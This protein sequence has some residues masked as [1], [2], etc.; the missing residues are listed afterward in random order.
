MRNSKQNNCDEII[1]LLVKNYRSQ[2]TSE[3]NKKVGE[4]A[5]DFINQN[6][7]NST[8]RIS[9]QLHVE[10]D[11]IDQLIDYVIESLENEYSHFPL[12]TCKNHLIK[13]IETEYKK[14]IPKSAARLVE[15]NLYNEGM[16]K[17]FKKKIHDEM[18]KSKERIKIRCA[19]SK[20]AKAVL[21]PVTEKWYQNRTIQAAI[22]GAGALVF[23][24]TLGWLITF[25]VNKSERQTNLDNNPSAESQ[26]GTDSFPELKRDE[27]NSNLTIGYDLSML[28]Q[29]NREFP[30][31]TNIDKGFIVPEEKEA[32]VNRPVLSPIIKIPEEK[33]APE[34]NDGT[35]DEIEK[36]ELIKKDVETIKPEGK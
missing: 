4:I 36:E 18:D 32:D 22:I 29:L 21:K 31:L 27:P 14:L 7:F 1:D 24:S 3:L 9:K 8:A 25:Y 34:E 35:V 15:A 6:L 17:Q 28:R 12:R 2:K 11:Y 26:T 16:E 13:I 5:Q 30:L 33:I 19:L 20:K 10:F 23:V